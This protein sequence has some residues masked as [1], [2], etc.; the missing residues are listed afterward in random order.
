MASITFAM[1]DE[2]NPVPGID[3]A[4]AAVL[5]IMHAPAVRAWIYHQRRTAGNRGLIVIAADDWTNP[6]GF[7][8]LTVPA[9]DADLKA[10]AGI[11]AKAQEG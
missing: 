11:R 1:S 8:S 7:G 6:G 3:C 10:L 9:S 5:F 2:D 4:L